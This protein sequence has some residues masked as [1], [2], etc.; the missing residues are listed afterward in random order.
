MALRRGSDRRRRM[1]ARRRGTTRRFTGCNR[2]DRCRSRIETMYHYRE[3]GLPN[4]Y[5]VNGYREIEARH[6]RGVSIEDVKGLQM[7]IALALVEEEPSLSGPEV[8]FIRKFLEP[9]DPDSGPGVLEA[10][11]GTDHHCH[12]S[13]DSST[14]FR[15]KCGHAG[16]S[17]SA[18]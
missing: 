14:G 2:R 3:C 1:A 9:V 8:R 6:G 18:G 12:R 16:H 17:H 15:F 5:L 11:A 13:T 10:S 7:A 4:V